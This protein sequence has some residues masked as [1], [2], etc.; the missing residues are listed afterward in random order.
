MQKKQQPSSSRVSDS[1]CDSWGL[2]I[3]YDDKRLLCHFRNLKTLRRNST[4]ELI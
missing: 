2:L 4:T 1:G 3:G